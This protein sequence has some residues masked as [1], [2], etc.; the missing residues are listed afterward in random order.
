MEGFDDSSGCPLIEVESEKQSE[1]YAGYDKSNHNR[2][3]KLTHRAIIASLIDYI[4]N[5][6]ISKSS[7]STILNRSL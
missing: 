3:W 2:T 5:S 6:N 4:S 7:I 1:H